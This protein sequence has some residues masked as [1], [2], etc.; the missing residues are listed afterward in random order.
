MY[1]RQD[2]MLGKPSCCRREPRTC[3]YCSWYHLQSLNSLFGSAPKIY[4]LSWTSGT[5]CPSVKWSGMGWCFRETKNQ[6]IRCFISSSGHCGWRSFWDSFEIPRLVPAPLPLVTEDDYKHLL[7]NVLKLR[8]DP[9]VKITVNQLVPVC[10]VPY[11]FYIYFV[12]WR[13]TPVRSIPT[14]W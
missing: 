13:I 3:R 7:H 2:S 14:C 8:N 9:A 6:D 12:Y 5:F 11:I 1:R 10:S 4:P